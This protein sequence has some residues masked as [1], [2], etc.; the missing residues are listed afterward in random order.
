MKL[1]SLSEHLPDATYEVYTDGS[2]INEETG[3]AVCILKDNDNS[4]NFLFKLKP[5]NSVFQA[6]LA[7][8]QFAANW[9]VSENSKINLYTDSLSSILALQS[10]SSR[11]NF[12]NKAKTELFK[13]KNLVGLSWVKAHVGIQGN[14]LADQQA[15][16]AT[17]TELSWSKLQDIKALINVSHP[18][19]MALQETFLKPNNY[20][21]LRGYSCVR[22]DNDSGVSTSGG[23][24]IFTSNLYPSTTLNL[25]TS[26]Q[27]IAV[28]VHF[29]TLVTICCI[30]LPPSDAISQDD[31]N[32]LVDQLPAPFILLGVITCGR[33]LD[34][35][36]EEI[37]QELRGQGVKD[38]RRIN[39]RRDGELVPT[40]HFILTFNTPRLPEYIKAGYV[41]CSVRSY[42]PNPLRCFKCQRFG[43]S[44][45]NCRGTLT[46]AR[47]A[48][49]GHESTGCTA[50][51]K[52]VNCQGQ[53]TS[54][55]R[56]CPKWKQEKEVISTKYQK[57]ISFPEA[58]RL[59]KAQV[60]PD[61]SSSGTKNPL[62]SSPSVG[63][64]GCPNP[65]V[66]RD[67]SS[68]LVSTPLRW[69]L[70]QE[71]KTNSNSTPLSLLLSA[72]YFH[73]STASEG[74]LHEKLLPLCLLLAFHGQPETR[75]GEAHELLP[76]CFYCFMDSNS[77]V[78]PCG[79]P[80][81]RL[82]GVIYPDNQYIN[83]MWSRSK[84]AAALSLAALCGTV[85]SAWCQYR[86][87]LAPQCS[88]GW[89]YPSRW[90]PSP[91]LGL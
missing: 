61:V 39:I 9:A 13:A 64:Y 90:L 87:R 25:H 81:R 33:L 91:W 88:R 38:V 18:V 85:L 42:I 14:E 7:A 75:L 55:S 84:G 31:L 78:W 69:L 76:L 71:N 68:L 30:Y 58:R 86:L 49:A 17:T 21:K 79:R 24:C 35:P 11:S 28:Q 32:I 54:F 3:L 51:E 2:K 41:R 19:C 70:C 53:H 37:T 1:V 52:C 10:A 15:K 4:Q 27:A 77:Y 74:A 5:Y 44:K 45:T 63:E 43:H 72:A 50:V 65:E 22:K 89:K 56:S 47:C 80:I 23:V 83:G 60:P 40:K 57:N 8:I 67:I 73:P 6:E 66:P 34:L 16:L 82:I 62:R 26:L 59:V 20:L 36:I 12:V 46:C 48:A 29:R